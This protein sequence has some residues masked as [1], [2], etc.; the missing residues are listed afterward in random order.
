[1]RFHTNC[2]LIILRTLKL[3][4]TQ[5]NP[6]TSSN[7]REVNSPIYKKASMETYIFSI[8]FCFLFFIRL[9]RHG[10]YKFTFY[11]FYCYSILILIYFYYYYYF[12]L[13]FNNMA[14]IRFQNG[15]L[16]GFKIRSIEK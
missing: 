6:N 16:L 14:N 15:H 8:S 7:D 3:N 5:K 4:L 9:P 1:M 13:K 12:N 10:P 11:A 2:P